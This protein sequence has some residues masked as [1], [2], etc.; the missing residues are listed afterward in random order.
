MLIYLQHGSSTQ[1][2]F[3]AMRT[4]RDASN[5]DTAL[6]PFSVISAFS[7]SPSEMPSFR[8]LDAPKPETI[9]EMKVDLPRGRKAG[10]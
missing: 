1:A 8:M 4:Y 9:P 3:A 6:S 7:H 5:V 2:S 10:R